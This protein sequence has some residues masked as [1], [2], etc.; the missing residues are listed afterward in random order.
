[1]VRRVL[2]EGEGEKQVEDEEVREK[3]VG[4]VEREGCILIFG[5]LE[6]RRRIERQAG[7]VCICEGVERWT[8]LVFC[9]LVKWE[10]EEEG[11]GEGGLKGKGWGC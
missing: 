2:G 6:R 3:R 11:G 4:G 5:S 7:V 1:M 10:E 8:L 9:W